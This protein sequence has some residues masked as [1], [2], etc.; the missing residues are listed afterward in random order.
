[1]RR[2]WLV[3]VALLPGCFPLR[4]DAPTAGTGPVPRRPA[5]LAVRA[6]EPPLPPPATLPLATDSSPDAVDRLHAAAVEKFAGMHSY[7]ARLRRRESPG[8]NAKPEEMMLFKERKDP[9]SVHFKWIGPEAKGREVVYVRGGY[10]DKLN[11]ITAAGDIPFAPGGRRMAL[12][13]DSMLVKAANPNHDITDA[14]M[15]YNLR[16]VGGL[17]AAAKNPA[18]GVTARLMRGIVRPEFAGPV[19]GV[20]IQLPPNRDPDLPRGGL[21]QVFYDP[22]SKLPTLY[23]SFDEQGRPF[24]YNFYDRLQTDLKLDDDD[25]NPDKLW[26]PAKG[27]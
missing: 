2:R 27:P 23:L 9:F 26:G 18:S 14:G 17:L 24:G 8:G 21:R 11:I 19:D 16:D 1:M 25:F 15:S 12:A 3:V 5:A 10:G 20:E 6:D 13:R 7:V 22:V 4:P